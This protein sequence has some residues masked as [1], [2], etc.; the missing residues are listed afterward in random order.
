[1]TKE[2]TAGDNASARSLAAFE[3]F[4]GLAPSELRII[5]QRCSWRW[6]S[7]GGLVLDRD[8]AGASVHFVVAG[9]CR[10]DIRMPTGKRNIVLDEIGP[11][12]FFGEIAAL[13]G[14]PRAAA[15]TAVV[16]THTAEMDSETFLAFLA[17]HPPAALRVM[18]RLTEV[19]RQADSTILELSGLGAQAR[20]FLELLRR[21]RTGGGLPPNV[22]AIA[23]VPQ[24]SDIA[25]RASTARETVVRA[26]SSLTRRQLLK[27]ER[28]RLLLTDIDAL[29]RLAAAAE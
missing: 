9:R 16:R 12:G 1:M 18:R 13:D 28:E 23:P 14:E 5:E 22:G 2:A 17:A 6:W 7:A 15:V 29:T 4:Q 8:R 3:L 20:V 27:R 11:G 21:A 25:A 19:I 24:H 26:L 10:I